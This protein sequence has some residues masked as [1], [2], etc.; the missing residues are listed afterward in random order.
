MKDERIAGDRLQQQIAFVL[1]LDK[2]KSVHRVT[3]LLHEDRRENAAEHSWHVALLALVLRDYCRE[4]I[5]F[6]RV[7]SLLLLH[8]SVEIY[9]G[10]TYVYD[11]HAVAQQQ[12][13]ESAA[14]EQL[15]ALLPADQRSYCAE[16][17]EE[18]NAGQT[19]EARYAQAMVLST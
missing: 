15:F 16:L 2:L 8:D 4:P 13:R 9:A 10:D 1:E 18:F 19:P 5:N 14:A 3:E 12:S 11:P 7:L 6:E 17:F